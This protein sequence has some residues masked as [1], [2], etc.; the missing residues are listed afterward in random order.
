LDAAENSEWDFANK[1]KIY[2]FGK[3]YGK[4]TKLIMM[5]FAY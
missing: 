4:T 2:G 5:T 3:L 1:G